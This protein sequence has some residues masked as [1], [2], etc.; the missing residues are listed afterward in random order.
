MTPIQAIRRVVLGLRKPQ[1]TKAL[2]CYTRF[3]WFR[4]GAGSILEE[5]PPNLVGDPF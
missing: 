4:A 1:T 5:I 3:L 2:H